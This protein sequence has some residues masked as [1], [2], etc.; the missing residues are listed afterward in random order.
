MLLFS[1][2]ERWLISDK[3]LHHKIK[4]WPCLRLGNGTVNIS[5]ASKWFFSPNYGLFKAYSCI[6][7]TI[8][9]TDWVSSVIVSTFY[10]GWLVNYQCNY[11]ISLLRRSI[12][13]A[14]IVFNSNECICILWYTSFLPNIWATF[15][16]QNKIC[17]SLS[18]S[19]S[20][21]N[22]CFECHFSIVYI[23][24]SQ[25]CISYPLFTGTVC[26]NRKGCNWKYS[27]LITNT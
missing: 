8:L 17:W 14:A 26:C 22:H 12:N 2:K 25:F 9:G 4:A 21:L 6:W 27:H 1:A 18:Q 19:E 16:L 15:L 20:V 7:Y 13:T 11:S 24:D 10:M 3:H 23:A 5:Y